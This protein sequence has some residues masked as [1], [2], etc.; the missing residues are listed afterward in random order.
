MIK[1]YDNIDPI[2][3]SEFLREKNLRGRNGNLCDEESDTLIFPCDP[4]FPAKC[5]D[6]PRRRLCSLKSNLETRLLSALCEDQREPGRKNRIY[7]V[8]MGC[9]A[10][11][12]KGRRS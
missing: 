8:S 7:G 2:P 12:A 5:P 6:Y 1:I 10:D 11:G 3:R 4:K 9:N